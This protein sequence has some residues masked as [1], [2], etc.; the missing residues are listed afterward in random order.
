MLH[1]EAVD[2]KTLELL[3]DLLSLDLFSDLRLVGGTS[4]ALQIG[5]RKSIDLDLFGN[6][7]ADNL[8]INKALSRIGN[9]TQL[10][11]SKN[12]HIY[13]I[14]GLKVDIVNYTYPWLQGLM[15][16]NAFRLAKSQDIAAMKLSA[17]TGRGTKKDF[18]DL[19]FLLKE[20]TLTQMLQFYLNKFHDGSLFMVMKSLVYFEDAETDTMPDML[21]P[22]NWKEVK[23]T[24]KAAHKD[25]AK[26]QS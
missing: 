22:V 5:H 3:K 8:E 6:I 25:Y 18:I 13:L 4:L 10:K 2:T 16:E 15:Q 24:I 17:I 1:Y 12:I 21:I 14:N 11:D 19:Y 23:K 26:K 9:I 20:W 7:N